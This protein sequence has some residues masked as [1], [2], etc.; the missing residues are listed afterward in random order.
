MPASPA[1]LYNVAARASEPPPCA[2]KPLLDISRWGPAFWTVFHIS[3]F[4]L[5]AKAGAPGGAARAE[6]EALRSLLVHFPDTLPCGV[7]ASHLREVYA[8]SPLPAEKGAAARWSVRVHNRVNVRLNK[9]VLSFDDAVRLYF[10]CGTPP[11]GSRPPL[12]S[13]ASARTGA[14][15]LKR[16][17]PPRLPPP[18]SASAS[19]GGASSAA[20]AVPA[21]ALA[22]GALAAKLGRALFRG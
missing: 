9:P 14:V 18:L 1:P 7:C 15:G 12:T 19:P 10:V 16:G 8:A 4:D 5:D 21:A 2:K 22:A 20:V 6:R 17:R 11:P 3:A 13:S